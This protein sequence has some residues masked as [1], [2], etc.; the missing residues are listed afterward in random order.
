MFKR[1]GSRATLGAVRERNNMD[2]KSPARA[3]PERVAR[4]ASRTGPSGVSDRATGAAHARDV[5]D[6]RRRVLA[7]KRGF[8]LTEQQVMQREKML[9]R[10]GHPAD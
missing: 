10:P 6:W 4:R 8:E 1:A 3:T 2:R 5:R 7:L 9:W